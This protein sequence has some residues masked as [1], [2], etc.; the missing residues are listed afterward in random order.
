MGQIKGKFRKIEEMFLS[1][2]PYT[3]KTLV[4]NLS[5]PVLWEDHTKLMFILTS[6]GDSLI[7]LGVK[8]NIRVFAV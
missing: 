5:P 4:L 8:F 1:L 6:V 7:P 3:A 2:L